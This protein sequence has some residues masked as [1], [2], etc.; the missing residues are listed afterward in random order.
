MSFSCAACFSSIA[1]VQVSSLIGWSEE[2][3]LVFDQFIIGIG[4]D[5]PTGPQLFTPE[6]ARD[7][8]VQVHGPTITSVVYVPAEGA[9]ICVSEATCVVTASSPAREAGS[10]FYGMNVC[11]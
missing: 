3:G 1:E 5:T 10:Q 8:C 4:K 11:P 9:A 2:C 6:E 7:T